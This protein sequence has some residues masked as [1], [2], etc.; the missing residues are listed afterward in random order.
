MGPPGNPQ[1]ELPRARKPERK[2]TRFSGG[3]KKDS[4]QPATREA[5]AASEDT[6]QL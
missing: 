5:S 1:Q 6:R 2:G 3:D 4:C